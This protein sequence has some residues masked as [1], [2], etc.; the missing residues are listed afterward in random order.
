MEWKKHWI[1]WPGIYTNKEDEREIIRKHLITFNYHPVFLEPKQIENYY[2]GYSNSIIW[3]LCHY[4]FSFIEY[5]S[6]YCWRPTNRSINS[7][8][9]FA[10]F[11]SSRVI[12]YG[13]QDYHL[14]LLP[15]MLR[16]TIRNI[17]VGYFH[18]IPFPFLRTF[19]VYF[20]NVRKSLTDCWEPT[21]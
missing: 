2:E 11:I 5:K 20:L 13:V 9:R 19:S 8:H 17:S 21:L 14:M 10:S 6:Q 1:G 15:K 7:F 3:P 4:F 16:G 12:L 18:H